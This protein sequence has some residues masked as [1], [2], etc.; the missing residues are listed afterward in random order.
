[1]NLEK[2]CISKSFSIRQTME[3][4]DRHAEQFAIILLEDERIAGIVTDGNIRRAIIAG[5]TLE[6]SITTIMQSNFEVCQ[7]NMNASEALTLMD[8]RSFSHL[9]IITED[10]KLFSIWN[11]KELQ[12][13]SILPHTVVIMAGG[14]G[15]RLGSLTK[16]TPKP[17]L[18]LVNRPILEIILES[19][20]LVGFRNFIFSV[21]YK[22]EIITNYFQDGSRHHCNIEYIHEDKCLGTAG[23]LSLLPTMEHDVIIANGDILTHANP[24]HILLHHSTMQAAGTMLAKRFSMQ[25]PYGVVEATQQNKLKSIQEKPVFDFCISAGINVLT[26][27]VLTLIPKNTF[28]D[29]PEL[30]KKIMQLGK[31]TQLFET[32]DYWLDVGNPI[33]YEKALKDFES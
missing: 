27:E 14:L 33:D 26:P 24:R 7:Q 13:K 19:F 25:V 30:F 31:T 28:F 4:I 32:K 23:A 3:H 17:M 8:E 16:E 20:R 29:M 2:Y 10:Q 9:P 5:A 18:P 22:A 6:S 21:N 11:K 12:S 15:T 1:M